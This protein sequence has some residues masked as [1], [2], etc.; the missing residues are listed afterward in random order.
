MGAIKLQ[1]IGNS[2]GFRVGKADLAKAGFDVDSEYEIVADR[3]VLLV[4][5]SPPP[6]SEW[7]FP[8]PELTQEDKEW[9]DADLGVDIEPW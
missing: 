2:L 3:G 9:L 6:V 7:R 5:K 8:D 1:K 4:V